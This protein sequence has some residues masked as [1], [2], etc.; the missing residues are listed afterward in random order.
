MTHLVLVATLAGVAV[1]AVGAA[2]HREQ[3]AESR[4][5]APA[6][7][8][9]RVGVDDTLAIA[10]L[11]APELTLS[12]RV[13][14]RGEILLPLLGAVPVAGLTA[15]EVIALL[16]ARLREQYMRDPHVTVQVTDT[17]SHVVSIVGAVN[18]PGA[19]QIRGDKALLEVLSL[20]GGLTTEA[21]ES[22][23]IT[24]APVSA[25]E[26]ARTLEVPLRALLE[27]S[28]PA[29]NVTIRGG[30]VVTVLQAPMIYIVGQVNKPGA[31]ALRGNG[32]P[33]TV[34][35]A[36]ALG[37]GL[38]PTAAKDSTIILRTTPSGER[39]EV[40]IRLSRILKMRDPD[41]PLQAR[42]VLFVPVSGT[43][44]AGKTALDAVS[45]MLSIRPFLY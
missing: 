42:D 8:D 24:R 5:I 36:L 30:D 10:V 26:G 22:I 32:D 4:S 44:A 6:G 12:V 7:D 3:P 33:L 14:P 43:R 1:V 39:I 41:V 23:L 29:L 2:Q 20:A 27:A 37:E 11:Q 9:Y 21:G 35:R 45:R 13:S 15:S 19:V 28:D 18:K 16:T 40:P 25:R 17:P 38:A 34:L 31:F